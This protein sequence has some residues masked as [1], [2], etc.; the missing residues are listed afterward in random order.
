MIDKELY[1]NRKSSLGFKWIGIVLFELVFIFAIVASFIAPKGGGFFE[2]LEAL[3]SFVLGN[4]FLYYLVFY[5]DRMVI[6]RTQAVPLSSGSAPAIEGMV[7]GLS[8]AAGIDRP[9]IFII[10]E[11]FRNA[12]SIGTRDKSF[13]F[14]TRGLIKSMDRDEMEGVIAHEIA[15]IKIGDASPRNVY[16]DHILLV[17][18]ALRML[19]RNK[20]LLV[21]VIIAWMLPVLLVYLFTEDLE[22]LWLPPLTLLIFGVF[23][24]SVL[25]RII[26][27]PELIYQ[28]RISTDYIADE[29]AIRW[30]LNPV[31]YVNA[32]SKAGIRSTR[33]GY[34]FLRLVTFAPIKEPGKTW[35]EQVYDKNYYSRFPT[36][37]TRIENLERVTRK[38][39]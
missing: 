35:H 13:I 17:P 36:I 7:E 1:A 32:L 26:C 39:M 9:E 15:H 25:L 21:S 19:F 4:L 2:G 20:I 16:V 5:V 28:R 10:N 11:G 22:A 3:V 14:L 29:Q 33:K 12:F 37:K 38:D 6:Y 31:P 8:I 30:T 23:M 18:L 27:S 24:P 34:D